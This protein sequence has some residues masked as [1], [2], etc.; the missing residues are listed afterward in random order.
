MVSFV[1]TFSTSPSPTSLPPVQLS[2]NECH[3]WEGIPASAQSEP[4]NKESQDEEADTG[5]K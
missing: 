2:W 3:N 4:D 5:C 1:Q